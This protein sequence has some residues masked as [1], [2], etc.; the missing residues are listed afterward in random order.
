VGDLHSV[1]EGSRPS[2]FMALSPKAPEI[3]VGE[4]MKQVSFVPSTF[5]RVGMIWIA[6]DPLPMTPIFLFLKS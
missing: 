4:R 5:W 1:W 2:C 3:Q 6:L